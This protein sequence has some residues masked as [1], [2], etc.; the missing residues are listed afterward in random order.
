MA[1]LHNRDGTVFH[2]NGISGKRGGNN[3]WQNVDQNQEN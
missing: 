3:N 2:L 1:K